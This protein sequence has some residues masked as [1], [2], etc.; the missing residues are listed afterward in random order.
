MDKTA[1]TVLIDSSSTAK[2][3][4]TALCLKIEI[5][6]S[7][8]FSLYKASE[9]N[10]E[11]ALKDTDLMPDVLSEWEEEAT[12]GESVAEQKFL[13]KRR[14]WTQPTVMP[15]DIIARNLIYHQV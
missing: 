13:F 3:V 15:V 14:I 8:K 12:K 4:F 1:K 9:N 2:E 10:V 5:R 11:V 6:E 7:A